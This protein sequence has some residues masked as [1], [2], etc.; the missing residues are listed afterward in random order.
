M[1][2]IVKEQDNDGHMKSNSLMSKK[3][4]SD[5]HELVTAFGAA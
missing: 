3:H 5:K 1:G 4:T 2:L